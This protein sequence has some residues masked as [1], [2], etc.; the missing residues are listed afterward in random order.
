MS[1]FNLCKLVQKG[2]ILEIQL[3]L[4]RNLRPAMVQLLEVAASASIPDACCS[5]IHGHMA[6]VLQLWC[7]SLHVMELQETFSTVL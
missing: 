1:H 3:P 4:L 2:R 7:Y 6:A 5:G